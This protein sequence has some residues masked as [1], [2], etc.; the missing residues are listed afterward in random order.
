M[1]RKWEAMSYLHK[2]GKISIISVLLVVPSVT[3]ANTVVTS[4]TY[5]D[6]QDS[7]KQDIQI[8]AEPVGNADSAD[9]GKIL[10]V[11]TD[12][13][14]SMGGTISSDLSGKEDKSNKLNGTATTG[15]K[16]GFIS[17]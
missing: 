1:A 3:F 14:I 4:Q 12:G 8:G 5:V 17:R 11:D 13:K 7:L 10:V 9:A 15:Q 2:M 6:M 16:I